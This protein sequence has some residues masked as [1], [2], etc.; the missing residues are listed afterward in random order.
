MKKYSFCT[1]LNTPYLAR[2]LALYYSLKKVCDF[3]LFIFTD[4]RN[5]YDWLRKE[6]LD[7]LTVVD[8]HDIVDEEL[9]KLKKE[10]DVSEYYWS[11]KATCLKHV[12][13]H[14]NIEL[15]SWV[16]GDTYFYNSP[17]LLF[18]D[19]GSNSVLLIPHNYSDKY[20]SELKYGIYNAGFIS[21]KT[22]K[23][24]MK[25]LDWWDKKCR[26]WCNR[27]PENGL[28]ADQTYLNEMAGF[29]GVKGLEHPGALANWNVQRYSFVKRDDKIVGKDE[30]Q[31]FDVIF[32]HFHYLKF[33]NDSVDLGGKFISNDVWQIFYKPYI[34]ELLD[35]VPFE[36]QGAVQ[37]PKNLKSMLSMMKRKFKRTYNVIPLSK[38]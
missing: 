1:I 14:N 29:P 25:A 38:V 26:E 37:K 2:G 27:K 6:S 31:E 35:L 28:F 8:L 34:A 12:I 5:C 36:F 7:C 20:L 17:S 32:Y 23:N 13:H 16:D 10:R 9:K 18:N 33:I 4:D 21:F 3:E 30:D 11:I 22:D 19:L 24:G 15:I